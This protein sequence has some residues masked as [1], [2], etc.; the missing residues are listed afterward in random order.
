MF[1]IAA[2]GYWFAVRAALDD[3][4]DQGLRFRLIGLGQY[5]EHVDVHGRQQIAAKLDE[6]DEI[7]E[8]YQVFDANG[9]LIPRSHG[10]TRHNVRSSRRAISAR[11]SATKRADLPTSRCA[12]PGRR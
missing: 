6:I 9:H 2:A 10:L 4:L 7:G 11:T 12:W 5:L 1:A 3:A 8:L